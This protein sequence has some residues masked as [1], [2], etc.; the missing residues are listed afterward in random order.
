MVGGGVGAGE[1]RRTM[2]VQL[3][4]GARGTSTGTAKDR[5]VLLE[6]AVRQIAGIVNP[7]GGGVGTRSSAGVGGRLE[8]ARRRKRLGGGRSA[9]SVLDTG[10]AGT[11]APGVS[12]GRVQ[13]RA[14]AGAAFVSW[15]SLPS[16]AVVDAE[17]TEEVMDEVVDS[18]RTNWR[19]LALMASGRVVVWGAWALE[20]V[21]RANGERDAR[22]GGDRRARAPVRP[23]IVHR[24]PCALLRGGGVGMA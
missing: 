18:R 2:G 23:T 20:T 6:D 15:M 14:H 24:C 21:V 5:S 16:E 19:R 9:R 1:R 11:N 22:R 10:V 12:D 8:E 13:I 3:C 4:A 7:C 17:A